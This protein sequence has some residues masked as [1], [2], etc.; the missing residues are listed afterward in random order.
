MLTDCPSMLY[1][2]QVAHPVEILIVNS[3]TLFGIA[4]YL[5]V[6]SKST[7]PNRLPDFQIIQ[8]VPLLAFLIFATERVCLSGVT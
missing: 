8:T 3:Y 2:G 5:Q 1:I 6:T 4:S 7:L